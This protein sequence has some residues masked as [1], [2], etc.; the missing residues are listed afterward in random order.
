MALYPERF[1]ECRVVRARGELDLTTAPALER[2]LKDARHSTGRLFVV[3]DLSR[4]T[5]M[6]GSVL[7][8]LCAAWEDC[9]QRGGWLRVVHPGPGPALVIRAAGLLHRFP[10]YANARDAW[11]GLRADRA[12]TGRSA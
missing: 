8:P 12:V 9:R 10:P 3:V 11:Q 4:V 2:D 5:F 7:D 6:D 1:E